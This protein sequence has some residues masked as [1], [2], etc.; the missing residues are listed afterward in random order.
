MILIIIT[1]IL[2]ILTTHT[3]LKHIFIIGD[4]TTAITKTISIFIISG[5]IEY[6]ILFSIVNAII[7]DTKNILKVIIFIAILL[8]LLVI[9]FFAFANFRMKNKKVFAI[10]LLCIL[11]IIETFTLIKIYHSFFTSVQISQTS[12][13]T[14]TTNSTNTN[15]QITLNI[16]ATAYQ[17]APF[18][19]SIGNSDVEI[20]MHVTEP[21]WSNPTSATGNINYLYIGKKESNLS[22]KMTFKVSKD[23]HLIANEINNSG[24]VV[25]TLD[26]VKTVSPPS[27]D[28]QEINLTGTFTNNITG[29]IEKAEFNLQP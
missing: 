16:L 9:D 25:G 13:T 21:A 27:V 4:C 10:V 17:Y 24:K 8:I 3:I 19:G 18:D 23:Q 29:Q 12:N 28:S 7:V 6:V 2:A 14:N 26:L 5:I 20:G 1:V 22:Y 15:K 11:I